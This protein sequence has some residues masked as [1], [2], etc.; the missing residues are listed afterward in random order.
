MKPISRFYVYSG[1]TSIII[2]TLSCVFTLQS[3]IQAQNGAGGLSLAAYYISTVASSTVV[4]PFLLRLFGRKY[5]LLLGDATCIIFG[6]TL[7]L[8][9]HE[10]P[11]VVNAVTGI[12]ACSLWSAAFAVAASFASS[13]A[14]VDPK[15]EQSERRNSALFIAILSFGQSLINILPEVTLRNAGAET[16]GDMPLNGTKDFLCGAEDCPREYSAE[17]D[18]PIYKNLVPTRTSLYIFVGILVLLQIGV[19]IVH[20]VLV[21]NDKPTDHSEE[22][23]LLASREKAEY[24]TCRWRDNA[25]KLFQDSLVTTWRSLLSRESAFTFTSQIHFAFLSGFLWLSF[26][27]SFISC[28]LG[29]QKVGFVMLIF[30]V[31]SASTSFIAAHCLNGI[32][33]YFVTISKCLLDLI[34][35]ILAVVWVP[36]EETIYIV[37]VLAI[38]FGI[39]HGLSKTL[40]YSL[41]VIYFKDIDAG[42]TLCICWDGVGVGLGGI[43]SVNVC[44]M[45]I[46]YALIMSSIIS[47][48]T[49]VFGACFYNKERP[50]T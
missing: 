24:K 47:T 49:L 48:S 14:D 18:H 11:I 30:Y 39:C 2:G 22:S 1:A 3:S 31:V 9:S 45:Y 28:T 12:F 38:L 23:R 19:S 25:S 35:C 42:F 7:L 27:R 10:L 5:N 13:Y 44:S 41:P 50:A 34:T 21:P 6:I 4:Y 17:N 8:P 37:Y 16:I 15:T 46:L 29:V 32:R 40:A 33:I 43:L 20:W 26:T 36:S